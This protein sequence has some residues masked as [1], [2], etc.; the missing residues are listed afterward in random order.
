MVAGSNCGAAQA[1]RNFVGRNASSASADALI[2]DYRLAPEHP[3][4]A[5]VRDLEACYRGLVTG[6]TQGYL[7][8][9]G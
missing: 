7:Q 9:D 4:P 1:F 8:P 5:A 6:S 3:L 2:P